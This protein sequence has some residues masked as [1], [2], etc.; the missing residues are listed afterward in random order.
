MKNCIKH[1]RKI[2]LTKMEGKILNTLV[3]G[4]WSINNVANEIKEKQISK[5]RIAL[6][7]F[8]NLAK[9]KCISVHNVIYTECE[10]KGYH[11]VCRKTTT[12]GKKK[13]YW[14]NRIAYNFL[15]EEYGKV[16][17]LDSY[18]SIHIILEKKMKTEFESLKKELL[19]NNEELAKQRELLW[20]QHEMDSLWF[21]KFNMLSEHIIINYNEE[22]RSL[23]TS[24][25]DSVEHWLNMQR[26]LIS[27]KKIQLQRYEMLTKLQEQF[28]SLN[29]L[30]V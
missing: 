5:I 9:R 24:I 10:M 22:D 4:Q 11:A 15:I 30:N 16:P 27:K 26:K 28:P 6:S 20:S 14:I 18:K 23:A 7:K 12:G 21:Q 3:N 2:K 1:T 17:T 8:D 19:K 13:T 25:N 29:I